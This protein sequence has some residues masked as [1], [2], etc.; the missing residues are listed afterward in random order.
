MQLVDE[1][2]S[3]LRQNPEAT[4]AEIFDPGLIKQLAA[5]PPQEYGRF[6]LLLEAAIILGGLKPKFS[7]TQLDKVVKAAAQDIAQQRSQIPAV[8][9]G[10]ACPNA[11]HTQLPLVV[12][13]DFWI[14]PYGVGI[15]LGPNAKGNPICE[16]PVYLS[17][18][19][20]NQE[21]GKTLLQ[22][23]YYCY[24]DKEWRITY[25]PASASS[26]A[27]VKTI[28]DMGVLVLDDKAMAEYLHAFAVANWRTL[29]L[30]SSLPE[31]D[32]F[33]DF[34]EYILDHRGLFDNDAGGIAWG[35]HIKNNNTPETYYLAVLPEIVRKFIRSKGAD[36]QQT[37]MVWR[38]KGYL[39]PDKMGKT[40][41]VVSFQGYKR[42]MF[43]F[44]DFIAEL[45]MT[46]TPISKAS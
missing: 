37:L 42:R 9:L 14:S 2:V 11:P 15:M 19:V 25:S 23:T 33:T 38:T 8:P 44:H 35:K 41:R 10:T 30:L 27:L 32:L 34:Q 22:I 45:A 17:G 21:Y 4:L 5:M 29:P 20:K 39:L 18:R 26:K 1:V 12:P 31:E 28:K 6:R 46:E 40:C 13:G 7:L 16:C 24:E 3:S 43:V 36:I